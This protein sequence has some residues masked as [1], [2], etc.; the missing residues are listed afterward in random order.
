MV[1]LLACDAFLAICHL[2]QHSNNDDG[3]GY[4][5]RWIRRNRIC[6]M[7]D[8]FFT[9]VLLE[10]RQQVAVDDAPGKVWLQGELATT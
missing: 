8:I 4:V 9:G 3:I 6:T 7:M 10:G 1:E 5:Q 2:L